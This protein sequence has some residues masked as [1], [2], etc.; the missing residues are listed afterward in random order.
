MLNDIKL[1]G[2]DP[3]ECCFLVIEHEGQEYVGTLLFDDSLFCR[4]V[5]RQLLEHCGESI[6]QIGE[7][8]ISYPRDPTPPA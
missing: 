5:Y 2:I 8:D 3:C 7:I 4:E 1:S 6:H